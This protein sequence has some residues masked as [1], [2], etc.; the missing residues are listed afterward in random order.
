M[1][2]INSIS[3]NNITI[4]QIYV[5]FSK[6]GS[7]VKILKRI[8]E[9]FILSKNQLFKDLFN[10]SEKQIEDNLLSL[11]TKKI[12]GSMASFDLLKLEIRI[13]FQLMLTLTQLLDSITRNVI[14][15]QL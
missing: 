4:N 5:I 15:T 7:E 6:N 10:L 1:N 12:T 11:H 3:T 8:I 9:P 2:K 14:F 13:I